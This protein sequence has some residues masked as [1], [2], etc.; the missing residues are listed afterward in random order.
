MQVYDLD[1][2][3]YD[4][5]FEGLREEGEEVMQV[6]DLDEDSERF[7]MAERNV[8]AEFP[9]APDAVKKTI[10]AYA[11][12]NMGCAKLLARACAGRCWTPENVAEVVGWT[13]SPV[14]LR[15]EQGWQL[16][17]RLKSKYTE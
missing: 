16:Y 2:D 3:P 14:E 11:D 1:E 8:N 10:L 17:L 6:Y 12:G 5:L 15:H 9:N 4:F 7:A 13:L